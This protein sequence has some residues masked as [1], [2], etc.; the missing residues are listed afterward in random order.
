[1]PRPCLQ[2]LKCGNI[3]SDKFND[4]CLLWYIIPIIT[5]AMIFLR[6][7]L[8]YWTPLAISAAG[9][10]GRQ[11]VFSPTKSPGVCTACTNW[12]YV[13][14]AAEFKKYI[15]QSIDHNSAVRNKEAMDP[16]SGIL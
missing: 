11:T 8:C 13:W 4:Q 1:M 15:G 5:N 9:D 3:L 2:S 16:I 14:K 7:Q 10:K 12:G 6:A